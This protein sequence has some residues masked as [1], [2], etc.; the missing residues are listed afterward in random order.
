MDYEEDLKY[1]L[2]QFVTSFVQPGSKDRYLQ[3]ASTPSGRKK[4]QRTMHRMS[5]RIDSRYVL[6]VNELTKGQIQQR[7]CRQGVDQDTRVL[8][9]VSGYSG[10]QNYE[11]LGDVIETMWNGFDGLISIVPGHLVYY[12]SEDEL[13]KW[14]LEKDA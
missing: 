9:L 4:F 10:R 2:E 13:I 7:V 1:H 8:V 12:G 14:L 11:K 5:A 6:Q 3:L